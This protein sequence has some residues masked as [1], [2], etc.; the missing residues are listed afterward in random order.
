MKIKMSTF[1]AGNRPTQTYLP[2]FS[3]SKPDS[4][5]ALGESSNPH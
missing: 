1:S 4:G 5:E 3:Q 2:V